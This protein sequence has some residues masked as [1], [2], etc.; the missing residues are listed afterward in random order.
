MHDFGAW[1]RQLFLGPEAS[2]RGAKRTIEPQEVPTT[3]TDPRPACDTP[4]DGQSTQAPLH[5]SISS[6]EPSADAEYEQAKREL[7][8]ANADLTRLELELEKMRVREDTL[9]EHVAAMKERVAK[10]RDINLKLKEA[11][12]QHRD[13]VI[14]ANERVAATTKQMRERSIASAEQINRLKGIID[15]QRSK[16]T[17]AHERV[18]QSREQLAERTLLLKEKLATS[19]EKL[20]LKSSHYNAAR[21][22]FGLYR[23]GLLFD[24]TEKTDVN[25]AA[26]A[27]LCLLPSSAP[28]GLSLSQLHGGKVFVDCVENVEVH[29]HSLAP[30]IHPPTLHLLNLAAYGAL[31]CADGILTVGNALAKTLTPFNS[32]VHVLPNFRRYEDTVPA[33]ELRQACGLAPDDHLLFAS[34]N[35]VVGFEPVIRALAA[36]PSNV[37]L[38][39]FVKLKPAEYETAILREIEELGLADRIHF[40]D[41]VEYSRL[42]SLAAD[43]DVGLITSDITNPNGAVALPNRLFDY[44]AAGLPVIAPPMPDVV[45]I[46]REYGFGQTLVQV[47]AENWASAIAEVLDRR[48]KYKEKAQEARQILT[49]ENSEDELVEF[50]GNPK[51]VTLIGFRDISRYQRFLRITRTLTSRGIQVK[52]LFLS[53]DP[54]PVEMPNTEFYGFSDRYG[55]G[56][57]PVKVES[58]KV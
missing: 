10:T 33:N 52:A 43:A 13:R 56:D 31:L 45:D 53:D 26:D 36:L 21:R 17:V 54:A 48:A 23:Q 4:N 50:L 24:E 39:A 22:Y 40:F 49:W 51:S 25:F 30:N 5:M 9:R 46:I 20:K 29:K 37:H 32:P 34:G 2:A 42:A 16:V 8:R 14:Q 58:R 1:C 11:L 7:A 41:F 15:D 19:N 6:N 12:Q 57:G 27:Y 47:N 44:L 35:V 55:V 38:A 3:A 28:A 18:R